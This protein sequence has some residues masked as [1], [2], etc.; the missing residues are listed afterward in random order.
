MCDQDDKKVA[1]GAA[2]S[3]S[4]MEQLKYMDDGGKVLSLGRDIA[5]RPALALVCLPLVS[6]WLCRG[7][8]S[9]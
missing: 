2:A 4:L 9:K 5:G 3:S 6:P 1:A 7:R 8:M